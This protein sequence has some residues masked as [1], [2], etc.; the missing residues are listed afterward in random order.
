M[1]SRV[2]LGLRLFKL[3]GNVRHGVVSS[4]TLNAGR[5]EVEHPGDYATLNSYQPCDGTAGQGSHSQNSKPLYSTPREKKSGVSCIACLRFACLAMRSFLEDGRMIIELCGAPWF[6]GLIVVS[7]FCGAIVTFLVFLFL[8]WWT[9][10]TVAKAMS[11]EFHYTGFLTGVFERF[12]FT[13]AIGLLGASGSG[14][15]TAMIGW[16][17]VKGQVHYK[18]FS[19]TTTRDMPQVYLGL[20]GSLASL[21]FAVLGGY[22][23]DAGYALNHPF[24]PSP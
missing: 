8:A 13:C 16:I 6:Y 11:E 2:G 4:P 23:W 9:G 20:L 18:I 3:H 15:M 17:A 5:F 12:F 7:T 1:D 24:T 21:L 10:A 14:V 22:L 19:D